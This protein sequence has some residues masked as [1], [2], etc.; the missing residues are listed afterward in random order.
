[1]KLGAI[2]TQR[3][4]G[5]GPQ[6]LTRFGLALEASGFDHLMVPDHVAV[7]VRDGRDP[8]LGGIYD[9]KDPFH[10]PFVTFAYLAA[11]TERLEFLTGVMVLPQRQTV[12]VAR[13][14]A[15]VD[16]LSGGRLSLGVGTGWNYVE[17]EA[18]G[19]DY[20]RRGR[21]LDEQLVYL[22]RLWAEE[23]F[24]FD[25][26]FHKL[27]RASI[28]PRPQRSIPIYC[29]GYVDAAYRRAAKLADGFIFVMGRGSP[30]EGW[31]RVQE[32][33]RAEGRRV[34]D[35]HAHFALSPAT[36]ANAAE[37]ALRLR[38]AGAAA[39]SLGSGGK[40]FSSLDQHLDFLTEC[41]DQMRAALR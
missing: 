38:D 28:A 33:L 11:I 21:K 30:L 16:L 6:V 39:L 8:P 14:A 10:D 35:F 4:M 41:R 5:G 32:L 20:H 29:G 34:E 36:P 7:A 2:Y 12:L 1:M 27:D 13:Q 3:E 24:S 18:L 25:G 9:E 37:T 26:Q 17:Y 19:E 15:D 40:G 22:R 31:A 23:A